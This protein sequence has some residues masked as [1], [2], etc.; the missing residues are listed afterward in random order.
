MFKWFRRKK[1]DKALANQAEQE[2]AT[3]RKMDMCQKAMETLNSLHIE[4]RYHT[5]PVDFERRE[6][7]TA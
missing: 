7:R 6:Q 2:I 3:I 1:D 5:V 4:R